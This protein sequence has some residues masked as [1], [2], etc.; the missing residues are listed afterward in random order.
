MQENTG[1]RSFCRVQVQEET[2]CNH[3][4]KRNKRNKRNKGKVKGM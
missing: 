1:K 3:K 4:N 2:V